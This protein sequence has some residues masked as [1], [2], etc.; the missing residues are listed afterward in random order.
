MAKGFHASPREILQLLLCKPMAD[1]H[2]QARLCE[3]R[4]SCMI[5][6]GEAWN[7]FAIPNH[8]ITFNCTDYRHAVAGGKCDLDCDRNLVLCRVRGGPGQNHEGRERD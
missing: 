4:S 7:P 1:R 8:D 6:R 5:S 3:Q 2:T